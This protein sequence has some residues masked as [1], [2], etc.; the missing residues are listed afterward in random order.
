MLEAIALHIPSTAAGAG[1]TWYLP[2]P[3][4]GKF[5]LKKAKFA[6]AT[7]VAA[8]AT[9]YTTVTLAK[10]TIAAPTTW[11]DIGT[12]NTN[13]GGTALVIGTTIDFNL[14]EGAGCLLSEGE[15]IRVTKADTASG[16]ILDGTFA[17]VAEK[18]PR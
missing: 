5:L 11:T 13:D 3:H 8:A 16:D 7:A 17:F 2:W 4:P 12:F 15:Q 6:P 10:N 1:D 18:V 9:D 14:T